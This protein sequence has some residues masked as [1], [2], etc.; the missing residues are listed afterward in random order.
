M[1]P[2]RILLLLGACLCLFVS[3]KKNE[4]DH[5]IVEKCD[6]ITQVIKYGAYDGRVLTETIVY[7]EKGRVKSVEGAQGDKSFYEYYNDKIVL[8]ATDISGNDTSFIYFLDEKRRIKSTSYFDYRYTYN[9]D[10]QLVSFRRPLNINGQITDLQTAL[11][12]ENGDLIEMSTL[13]NGVP[14]SKISFEYYDEPNQD[15][16]GYNQPLYVSSTLPIPNT[17]YLIKAGFFG[18]HSTHLYKSVN[19]NLGYG[20]HSHNTNYVKDNNGRITK[21]NSWLEFTYECP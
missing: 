2:S 14:F 16:M 15:L 9:Q 1:H 11:K 12:Y 4:N 21:M 18:K 13:L 19:F 7:D 17:S 20:S 8:S 6:N 3:C 5:P 10:G